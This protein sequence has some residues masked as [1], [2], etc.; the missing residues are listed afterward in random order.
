MITHG[1]DDTNGIIIGGNYQ[2]GKLFKDGVQCISKTFYGTGEEIEAE[3]RK[4]I[5]EYKVRLGAE[6]KRLFPNGME[7][8]I[9]N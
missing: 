3:A 8:R 4:Y 1:Y 7:L 2:M 6:Y 5:E 9:Y